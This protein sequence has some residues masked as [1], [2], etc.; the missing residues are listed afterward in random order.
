M[1]GDTE[2][3]AHKVCVEPLHGAPYN[4]AKGDSGPFQRTLENIASLLRGL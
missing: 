4:Q 2:A 1:W 3:F